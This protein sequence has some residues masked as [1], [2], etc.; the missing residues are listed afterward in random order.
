MTSS[1]Y[2]ESEIEAQF[3]KFKEGDLEVGGYLAHPKTALA[4]P[5]L[6]LTHEWYGL[7]DHIKDVARRYAREGFVTLAVDL[8]DGRV[9]KDKDEAAKFMNE[10]KSEE[11]LKRVR[12]AFNH[13][14]PQTFVKAGRIG[15]TG[16]CMGGSIA[17]LAACHISDLK[18]AAP[19]YGDI[20]DP[21]DPVK[22]I[23]CPLLF[24]GAG[25]DQWITI[26]KMERLTAAI[27]KY[28]IQGEVFIYPKAQHAFFNNMRPEVYNADAAADAWRRVLE[29][30]HKNLD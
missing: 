30:L 29:F 28:G 23:H 5:G 14:K 15:I 9:A 10:M 6:L 25:L 20:P 22:N 7:N 16:F 1:K 2:P 24:I 26:A 18:A 17:L 27:K 13:L 11:A 3:V 21:D 8:Y 19:F 4:L 12:A